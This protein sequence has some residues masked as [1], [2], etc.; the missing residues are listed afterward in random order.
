[1]ESAEKFHCGHCEKDFAFKHGLKRHLKAHLTYFDPY[2]EKKC[3]LCSKGYKNYETHLKAYHDTAKCP[4]CGKIFKLK[5]NL[6]DHILRI[7]KGSLDFQCEYCEKA[8]SLSK[9]LKLHTKRNHVYA[10]HDNKKEY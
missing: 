2:Q 5:K 1:M 6:C 3:N 7:H 4:I 8:Y 9:D 10:A